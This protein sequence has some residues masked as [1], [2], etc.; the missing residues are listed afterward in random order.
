MTHCSGSTR[1]CPLCPNYPNER[2]ESYNYIVKS[3]S[4]VAIAIRSSRWLEKV[5]LLSSYALFYKIILDSFKI[6]GSSVSGQT[7]G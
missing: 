3:F 6:A 7:N 5:C 1:T 4:F 2:S